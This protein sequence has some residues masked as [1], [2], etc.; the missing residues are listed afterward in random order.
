MT[1]WKDRRLF[2]LGVVSADVTRPMLVLNWEKDKTEMDVDLQ[3]VWWFGQQN[4][5]SAKPRLG[6]STLIEESSPPPN[7]E[8]SGSLSDIYTKP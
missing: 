1:S 6:I 3:T 2:C 4:H 7:L 8:S 5:G